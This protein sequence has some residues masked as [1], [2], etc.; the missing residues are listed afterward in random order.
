MKIF[1]KDLY[2]IRAGFFSLLQNLS[3][4]FFSIGS[5]YI[6][7]R[8]LGPNEYGVWVLFMVT[9][10]ILET[11]RGGLVQNALIRFLAAEEKTEHHKITAASFTIS[12]ILSLLCIILILGFGNFLAFIWKAPELVFIFNMYCITFIIS[13]ILTQFNCILQA[14][15]QFRSI[16]AGSFIMQFSFFAYA[17]VCYVFSFGIKLIDLVYVQIATNTIAA[18]I[19]YFLVK[20]YL[21]ISFNIYPEW[22]KKLFNYGKYAFGTSV[23][24]ILSVTVDQMMLG[25]ILSPVQAGA[26]NV[27]VRLTNLLD[28]PTNAVAVIVFPQSAKRIA[29]EGKEGIKYLYEKSVGTLIALL[30]PGILF[31][32]LF[33]DFVV[34]LVAGSNYKDAIPLL[35]IT[36]LYCLFTPYGRQFGNILDSIGKTRLTFF[37]VLLVTSINIG[38]NYLFIS[39][40]GVLGAAYATLTAHIIGFIIGQRILKRELNVNI[41]NTFIYAYQF[42]P[43]FFRKYIKSSV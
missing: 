4:V 32:Y 3:G 9:V 41:L 39:R 26:F 10:T 23:S 20:P 24:A 28:I 12:G 42:Y 11:V 35:H 14:N 37:V 31:L 40:F 17:A 27:A 5:F 33:S 1:N 22:I 8:I 15:L 29:T 7:L 36:L 43:E 21:S 34:Q 6:L 18:I 38:L 25:A 2:W 16:F 19:T 13:G 30:I